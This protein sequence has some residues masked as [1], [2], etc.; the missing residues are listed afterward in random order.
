MRF[1]DEGLAEH[2]A[3]ALLPDRGRERDEGRRIAALA[4]S[5]FHLRFEDL[6]DPEAFMRRQDEY[7]LYALGEVWVAALV[8]ACGQEAPARLLR[9]FGRAAAP[10]ALAGA[11]LWRHGLQAQGCDL[12]RVN[13]G[14]EEILRRAEREAGDFPIATARFLGGSDGDALAF[15]L[16]VQAPA[17]GAFETTLRVRADADAPADEIRVRNARVTVGKPQRVLIAPPARA[18]KR[19]E[20]QVGARTHPE[21]RPFFTRWQSTARALDGQR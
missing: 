14:S 9:T 13:G 5:R 18:G 8:E 19:L 1:F 7:L 11:D 15:E 3:Y 10:Q 20:L 12:E 2:V 21:G 4:H 6:L 17:G 16:A